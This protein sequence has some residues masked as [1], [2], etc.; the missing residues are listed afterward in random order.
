[1]FAPDDM[2]VSTDLLC[3]ERLKNL[4]HFTMQV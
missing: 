1:M 4:I 2:K 3:A